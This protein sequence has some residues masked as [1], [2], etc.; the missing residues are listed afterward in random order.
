MKDL[1]KEI[2]FLA[3]KEKKEGLSSDEKERQKVLREEYLKQFRGRM[4]DTLLN[5]KV[6]DEDGNDVTP[7]KLKKEQDEQDKEK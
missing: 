3:N 7:V 1:I 6:V 2:N 5:V 4:K